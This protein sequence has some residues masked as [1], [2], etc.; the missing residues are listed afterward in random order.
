MELE[1]I[2]GCKVVDPDYPLNTIIQKHNGEFD[3]HISFQTASLIN[4]MHNAVLFDPGVPSSRLS[5][6]CQCHCIFC[7]FR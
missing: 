6:L 7:H 2:F 1:G 4:P 3:L 5:M